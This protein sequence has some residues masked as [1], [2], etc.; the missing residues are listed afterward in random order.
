MR[1]RLS[2]SDLHQRFGLSEAARAPLLPTPEPA[3]I[4]F[5]T[6][7]PPEAWP[8]GERIALLLLRRGPLAADIVSHLREMSAPEPTKSEW[9]KLIAR[10]YAARRAGRLQLSPQG[11]RAAEHI[12]RDLGRK[13]GL[14]HTTVTRGSYGQAHSAKCVC[15]FAAF[16]PR[17]DNG[18]AAAQ[19]SAARHLREMGAKQ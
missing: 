5:D 12:M 19:A 6:Y 7:V 8:G 2:V 14:H 18:F 1:S 9:F 13:L 10:G 3:A 17:T 15:G 4:D 16:K 11:L